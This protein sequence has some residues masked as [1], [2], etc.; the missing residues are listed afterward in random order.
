MAL[1]WA[2]KLTWYSLKCKHSLIMFDLSNVCH[3]HAEHFCFTCQEENQTS[4]CTSN[5]LWINLY[6]ME[7]WMS[8]FISVCANLFCGVEDHVPGWPGVKAQTHTLPPVQG[9]YKSKFLYWLWYVHRVHLESSTKQ[10]LSTWTAIMT[11]FHLLLLELSKFATKWGN[12]VF[13]LINLAAWSVG[14]SLQEI[15]S[16]VHFGFSPCWERYQRLCQDSRVS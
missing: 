12:N 10:T 1:S 15:G 5:L 11:K 4:S 8:I 2:I 14:K 9:L 16:W 6:Y 7:L 3:I 13:D